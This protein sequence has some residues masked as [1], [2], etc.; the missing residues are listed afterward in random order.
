MTYKRVE[1][2][3]EIKEGE[4]KEVASTKED[5]LFG[6][7]PMIEG[8]QKEDNKSFIQYNAQARYPMK[9]NHQAKYQKKDKVDIPSYHEYKPPQHYNISEERGTAK[10]KQKKNGIRGPKVKREKEENRG[11]DVVDKSGY[12]VIN[13]TETYQS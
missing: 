12:I 13:E 9:T 2:Q 8:N 1:N 3:E 7:E 10:Y 6:S 4:F 11:F 5:N